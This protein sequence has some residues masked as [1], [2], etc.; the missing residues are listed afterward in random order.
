MRR[1]WTLRSILISVVTMLSLLV[2]IALVVLTR[3]GERAVDSFGTSVEGVRL[4]EE[5]EIE[6]LMHPRARGTPSA[7]MSRRISSTG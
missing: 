7:T 6:L 3:T 1:P 5:A 4:A 2:A